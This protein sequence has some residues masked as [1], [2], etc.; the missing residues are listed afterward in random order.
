VFTKYI[1]IIYIY[2]TEKTV[3]F[4][5]KRIKKYTPKKRKNAFSKKK[6][7]KK[8][9]RTLYIQINIKN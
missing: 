6:K 1:Y 3:I 8:N 9:M 4:L 2:N 5:K 7:Y